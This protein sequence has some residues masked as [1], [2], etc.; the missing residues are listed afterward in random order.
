MGSNAKRIAIWAS[1]AAIIL[2][3]LPGCSQNESMLK[4]EEDKASAY[5]STYE[6]FGDGKLID[7]PKRLQAK[8]SPSDGISTTALVGKWQG[9][10]SSINTEYGF[11]DDGW[12]YK[13]VMVTHSHLN[14]TY[15]N[16]Y[17]SGDY[18]Y[19]G[20]WTY[21]TTY[22]YTYMD[23]LVGE[24]KVKG[25]VIEFFHVVAINR[26]NFDDD[27]YHKDTRSVSMDQ[28][29]QNTTNASMKS[30]FYPE[31]EFVDKNRI[32]LRDENED[33]DLFWN[34]RDVS[35][36][37]PIPQHEIPPVSWPSRALSK[38]M[39]EYKGA[40]R[41]REASLSYS[42][43]DPNIKPEF[44]TVTVVADKC[45]A[46]QEAI[47]YAQL[48]KDSS[49]WVEDFTVDADTTYISYEAR[50]GMFKLKASNGRGSG[51]SGDTIV[52]ESTKHQEGAWPASWANAGIPAPANA[53]I[54]GIVD[55]QTGQGEG[56]YETVIF[57]GMGE[58]GVG[59][60]AT[61]L[62][63]AGFKKPQYSSDDWDYIKYCRI[64]GQLYLCRIRAN[65][66]MGELA[67]FN[68]D[69]SYVEDGVWPA[70]WTNAGL[71]PPEGYEAI[72]GKIDIDSWTENMAGYSSEHVYAKF[73]GITIEQAGRY[74]D[75]LLSSGFE[76]IEDSWDD[77]TKVY[78]YLNFEGAMARVE[79]RVMDNEDIAEIRYIFNF[80]KPG[81]WP[82]S[83]QN[84]SV[85]PPD[86]YK[87]IIGAI[88]LDGWAEDLSG[89]YSRS[90][91]QTVKFLGL[92]EADI[93]KYYEKLGGLGYTEIEDS[94]SSHPSYYKY[95]RVDNKLLRV[96]INRQENS[97][98]AE[99]RYIFNYHEDGVWPAIWRSGGLPPPDG[100]ITIVG[101]INLDEWR[102]EISNGYSNSS[103]QYIKFLGVG[104]PGLQRY[105]AKLVSLGFKLPGD[106]WEESGLVAY[107]RIERKLFRVLVEPRENSEL[108]EILIRFEYCEDGEWP[109]IWTTAG[110]PEP[111]NTAIAGSI[112]IDE[113]DSNIASWGSYSARIKLVG[114]DL[115]AYATVLKSAGFKAPEYSYS[116]A[117]SLEKRVIING[118]RFD[119]TIEDRN[120]K[121]TSEIYI[122]FRQ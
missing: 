4:T 28:L 68:Y 27:W 71:A 5:Y 98:L 113:F 91:Y 47:Q 119:V 56:I 25:G 107:L 83:W 88:D 108:A 22:S 32:R 48:L 66:L 10:R 43:Y 59:A 15:H 96:E 51:T 36:N 100:N 64:S 13:N 16:G 57:D 6:L 72:A 120:N 103:Y 101:A 12:F 65:K 106:T 76:K 38:D 73:L 40:G 97:E 102:E 110:I 62:I 53:V 1:A 23:T 31:F 115:E 8:A 41:L 24:Y 34:L 61:K 44:K 84:G 21:N 49:W 116:D 94:W 33:M 104:K 58:S 39:P 67:S 19:Y 87:A 93:G 92:N 112:D 14:S 89:G 52:F 74:I 63:Q 17:W 3:C 60:Y 80:E 86:G 29:R 50:K 2:A 78:A 122:S 30:D 70:I 105:S 109:A 95:A 69:F 7:T 111:K 20:Y 75:K 90:S 9:I 37:V 54:V 18:Y 45:E 77:A 114:A 121:E 42:G 82:V 79:V 117:W 26:T 99:F 11:S 85:A 55:S 46:L 81:V 118:K 35:H